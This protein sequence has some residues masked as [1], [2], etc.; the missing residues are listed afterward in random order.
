MKIFNYCPSCR[1]KDISLYNDKK[2]KCK[3]CSFTFF[4]N[5]ATAVAVILE[6][7]NK[8]IL[9]KRS[10]EPGK[11]KWDLPGGFVDPKENAEDALKREMEEELKINIGEI[12]YFCSFP[13]IYEYKDVPYHTC[14]LFFYSS[15]DSIP[16]DFDRTEIE[17][18]LLLSPPEIP[19][20][21]I[22]FESTKKCLEL[23][24]N[25]QTHT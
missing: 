21:K 24:I 11:G 15:I 20:D 23:F 25:N 9:I 7:D 8:I 2:F 16:I 17:E 3:T 5:V 10:R 14:D 18:L 19:L 22:A 13:N 4:Q 12:K 6:H 1:S